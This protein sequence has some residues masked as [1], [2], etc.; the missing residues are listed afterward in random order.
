MLSLDSILLPRG[1]CGVYLWRIDVHMTTLIVMHLTLLG[2]LKSPC[3]GIVIIYCH[4][5]QWTAVPCSCPVRLC[6]KVHF[7]G[8]DLQD[9]YQ[10][11]RSW[12]INVASAS[13]QCLGKSV[14]VEYGHRQGISPNRC[15]CR[16]LHVSR[17][18][19]RPNESLRRTTSQVTVGW[20]ELH[21]TSASKGCKAHTV[22]NAAC[23]A[24]C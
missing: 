12:T 14:C 16:G 19:L 10:S 4:V 2:I 15:N 21:P 23:T 5:R 7:F 11:L 22:N 18:K 20:E 9:A 24:L 1:S 6:R 17:F 8:I 3:P 13:L